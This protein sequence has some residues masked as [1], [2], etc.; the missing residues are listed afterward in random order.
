MAPIVIQPLGLVLLVPGAMLPQEILAVLDWHLVLD[1]GWLHPSGVLAR[2]GYVKPVFERLNRGSTMH[3]L[4][5]YG[6]KSSKPLSLLY[7]SI[8]CVMGL[9]VLLDCAMRLLLVLIRVLSL[10]LPSS[11]RKR[12]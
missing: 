10:M 3:R 9:F 8:R 11:L 4:F 5:K 1:V 7:R 6:P 2:R 12:A